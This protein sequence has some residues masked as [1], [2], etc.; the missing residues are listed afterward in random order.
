MAT[1]S[2]WDDAETLSDE[3]PSVI[4]FDTIGDVFIG[5]FKRT[6]TVTPP[7]DSEKNEGPFRQDIFTVAGDQH[8]LKNGVPVAI[9]PGYQLQQAFDKLNPGDL[10]RVEYL[11][12]VPGTA[13]PGRNPLKDF[14]V[15][16]RR[17]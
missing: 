5:H 13:R 12:D 6:E 4:T 3:S 1:E 9:R 16:V 2:N 15:Q 10:T 11:K 7:E 17:G 8:G 14:K